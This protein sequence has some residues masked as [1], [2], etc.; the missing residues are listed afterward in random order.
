M[1]NLE[2]RYRPII[3]LIVL[4]FFPTIFSL[5]KLL[6]RVKNL[7][8]FN[9]IWVLY[10]MW[11]YCNQLVNCYPRSPI[12]DRPLFLQISKYVTSRLCDRNRSPKFWKGHLICDLFYIYFVKFKLLTLIFGDLNWSLNVWIGHL[13]R[14]HLHFFKWPRS[15]KLRL[16]L[17]NKKIKFNQNYYKFYCKL[18]FSK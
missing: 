16:I 10:V 4:I 5:K 3:F 14:D 15:P 17:M 6:K 8:N 12:G 2:K 11:P 7:Y 18:N 9:F 1:E 13:I